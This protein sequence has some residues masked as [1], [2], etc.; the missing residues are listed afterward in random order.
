MKPETGNRKPET[1]N[2]KPETGNRKPETGNRKPE[3]W[4]T[5]RP[6]R[7]ILV[8]IRNPATMNRL[9]DVVPSL[10]TD[11]RLDMW[12]TVDPGSH[13]SGRLTDRLVAAGGLVLTWEDATRQPFDLALAASDNSDLRRIRAPLVLLPHGAG[14][15]RH[16]PTDP[17][18]ISGLRRDALLHRG[19]VVPHTVVV[20]HERQLAALRG[21]DPRLPE[22]ALVAGDP[23]LDRIDASAFLRDR[24]RRAFDADGRTMVLLSSTW[25]RNSLFG[26][27]P[28][29]AERLRNELPADEYRLV[30]TL[31]PNVWERHGPLQVRAWLRP[32]TTSGAILIEPDEEWRTA[33]VSADLV[34][35]DHGSLTGYAAASGKPTLLATDGGSEVVAGSAMADLQG[36]LPRLDFGHPLLPQISAALTEGPPAAGHPGAMFGTRGTATRTVRDRMYAILD[37]PRPPSPDTP[38]VLPVPA[39]RATA[40]MSFQVVVRGI[41]VLGR[42]AALTIERRAVAWYDGPLAHHLAASVDA[43]DLDTLE[44]ASAIWTDELFATDRIALAWAR[45]TL[46]RLPGARL[47]LGR[48]SAS[49]FLAATRNGESITASGTLSPSMASSVVHWW[50]LTSPRERHPRTHVDAGASSGSL[51][52]G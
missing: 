32:A 26:T 33:L 34:I 23:C 39:P 42:R 44:R 17:R 52:P 27:H 15:H 46:A 19:R 50:S 31:H 11:R 3:T 6:D 48:T 12:F 2:R 29:L 35:S 24:Y 38:T 37:L 5:V 28:D 47:A 8:V 36:V 45:T 1:G 16:S 14:Y 18:S 22:R 43:T 25:G 7:R 21:I 13:F 10:A 49:T 30:L 40:P 51:H 4:D 9:W 41:R 20:A